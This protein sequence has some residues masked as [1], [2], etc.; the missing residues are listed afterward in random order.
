MFVLE[1]AAASG[2]ICGGAAG[3]HAPNRSGTPAGGV[4]CPFCATSTQPVPEP[5]PG[6]G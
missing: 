4:A 2:S 3:V 1:A 5:P 6:T